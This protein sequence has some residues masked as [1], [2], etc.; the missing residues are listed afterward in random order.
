V[1]RVR[2]APS[3]ASKVQPARRTLAGGLA[4]AK[5]DRAVAFSGGQRLHSPPATRPDSTTPSFA[6][7][8]AT[9]D[10]ANQYLRPQWAVLRLLPGRRV[11][12]RH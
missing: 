7:C 8:G 6:L 1:T 5:L 12:Q 4:F 10:V 9:A 2:A 3:R 11:S